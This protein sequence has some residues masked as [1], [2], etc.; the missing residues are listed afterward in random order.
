MKTR[1]DLKKKKN[2]LTSF[3]QIPHHNPNTRPRKPYLSKPP[4][5][6]QLSWNKPD[7]SSKLNIVPPSNR[8]P[9][10]LSNSLL[11][12]EVLPVPIP[13]VKHHALPPRRKPVM[14]IKGQIAGALVPR[15][16]GALG[17]GLARQDFSF[18]REHDRR[19]R[20]ARVRV[21]ER[22]AARAAVQDVVA[23]VAC[24]GDGGGDGG[25]RGG[26]LGGGGGYGCG[27]VQG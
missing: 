18:D 10:P 7:Q 26:V 21:R 3:A 27:F 2:S 12:L 19:I 4:L 1:K 8:V 14:Q 5:P 9:I 25:A 16:V 11:N 13:P 24:L 15:R 6:S 23:R 20:V 22:A 17:R